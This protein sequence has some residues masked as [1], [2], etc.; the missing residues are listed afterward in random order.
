LGNLMTKTKVIK[1]AFTVRAGDKVP[2]PKGNM[3]KLVNLNRR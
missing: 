3:T 2:M 1:I